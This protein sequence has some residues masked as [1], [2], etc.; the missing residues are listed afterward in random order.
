MMSD[1]YGDMFYEVWRS[2]GNPDAIDPDRADDYKVAGYEPD[3]AAE[4]EMRR[5]RRRSTLEDE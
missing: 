3:E 4:C 2:G 5:Q 1:Y